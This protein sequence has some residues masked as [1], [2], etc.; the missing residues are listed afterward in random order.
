MSIN[1]Q[2]RNRQFNVCERVNKARA[3]VE[4]VYADTGDKLA[5]E[6]ADNLSTLFDRMFTQMVEHNSVVKE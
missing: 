6:A 2:A 1:R 5:E 4:S 3:L